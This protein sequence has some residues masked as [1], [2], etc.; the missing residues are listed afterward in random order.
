MSKY[1]VIYTWEGQ[2]YAPQFGDYSKQ[3]VLA[4]VAD[5]YRPDYAKRDILVA[6]FAHCPTQAEIDSFARLAAKQR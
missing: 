5:T 3:V 2:A 6:P 4:E 1:Y